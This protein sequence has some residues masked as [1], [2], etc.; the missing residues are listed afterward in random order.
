MPRSRRNKQIIVDSD[1]DED[2]VVADRKIPAASALEESDDDGEDMEVMFSSQVPELSQD[3]L[4]VKAT[5][6]SN[7]LK[8][9]QAARERACNDMT[10]LVLFKALAGDPIVRAA[11]VQD[12][13]ISDHRVS[14]AVFEEVSIRLKNTFDFELKRI[15]AWMENMKGLPKKYKD[16]YYVV[17]GLE[18]DA[19]G[20]HSK[21]IHNVHEDV[22]IEKGLL[23]VILSLTYCKGDPRTDGSRWILDK[24]LYG[25]LNRIDENIPG[26]PPAQGTKRSAS[27]TQ[28]INRFGGGDGV[29]MTPDVDVLLDKFVT[30][31]YLIK[32][33]ATEERLVVSQDAEEGSM[34]YTM[35]PRAA[36]EIGRRQII[37]FAAEVLDDEEPDPTML[38]ELQNDPDEAMDTQGSN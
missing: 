24:D 11:C 29:A 21:A 9:T 35:G 31:D 26:E 8:M 7:L 33:K 38:A 22:A 5:E 16:R 18:D 1:D 25:L 19:H 32:E 4:P 10:R 2:M 15:P 30:R 3:I 6:R 13:G 20:H 27:S 23:M 17:N 12:A 36:M 37:Y 28:Q 14:N 34:F